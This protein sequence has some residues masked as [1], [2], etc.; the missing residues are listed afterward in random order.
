MNILNMSFSASVLILV[1]AIIRALLL[2]KLPKR[3]FLVFWGVVL[4]RLLIPFEISS[5][6]SI[7]SIANTLAS[8]FSK[9]DSL[10]NGLPTVQNNVAITEIAV[11]QVETSYTNVPPFMV[12]WFIGFVVCALF[13]FVTHLRCRREYKTALPVDN[14]VG[15][16][17]QQEHPMRRVVQVLQSDRICAPLT[18]GIFRPVVLLPKQTDWTDETR[19]LYILAHEFVHIQRFDTLTK[20][21]MATALCVHWFN[22]FVWL[23]Y[24]LANRDIE[25]T[26]DEAV[27]K[28]LGGNVKSAYALTLIGLVEKKNRF[29]PLVN[30]FS[31]NAIEERIVSIMKMK[32]P[33]IVGVIIA[34]TLVTCTITVFATSEIKNPVDK[35]YKDGV[36]EQ[37]NDEKIAD[38]SIYEVYGM[39]YNSQTGKFNYE[40]KEVRFFNDPVESMSFTNFYTGE[41]DV[42]AEYNDKNVLTGLKH[43]SKYDYDRRT[44]KHL[45]NNS[46]SLATEISNDIENLLN[47]YSQYGVSYNRHKA[48]WE[49]NGQ[50]IKSLIDNDYYFN[51]D[52]SGVNLYTK[53]NTDGSFKEF[54]ILTD[55]EV[56]QFISINTFGENPDVT[57]EINE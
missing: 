9:T 37:K 34:F 31:K 33:S 38:Y 30:N 19:L 47:A 22:P 16:L 46:N 42:E 21:I 17:W 51:S 41:V 14:E 49:Y 5:R 43:S 15:R 25:L 56:E 26:C 2:H 6:L 1:I 27:V 53:R 32:K 23:M 52:V 55:S 20:L 11:N 35:L 12:I 54:E 7:Y 3:T 8:R 44:Q 10:I 57:Q 39:I 48:S 28:T 45:A 36:V 24:I 50:E 4:C 40:G 18:Y 29:T 13:F